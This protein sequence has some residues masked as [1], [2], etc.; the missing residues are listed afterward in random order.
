MIQLSILVCI[1]MMAI[2]SIA[3]H[4]PR[5][6]SADVQICVDSE[7]DNGR[8]TLICVDSSNE[9]ELPLGT[10][11]QWQKDGVLVRMDST[12]IHKQLDRLIFDEV[13]LS[14]EG[15]WTCSKGSLSPPFKLYGECGYV[16]T[17]VHTRDGCTCICITIVISWLCMRIATY[18]FIN[19][20]SH[21]QL[22]KST[23]LLEWSP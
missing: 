16:A 10:D 22:A 9:F 20:T 11:V 1:T 18:D 17:S 15:N 5:C 21:S 23:L 4:D 19:F 14:D 12:R 8:L 2:P 3:H 13:L 7:E 6:L